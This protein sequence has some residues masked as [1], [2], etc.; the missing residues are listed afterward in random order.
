MKPEDL[1]NDLEEFKE[2]EKGGDIEPDN[3]VKCKH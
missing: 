3:Y 1:L 2:I